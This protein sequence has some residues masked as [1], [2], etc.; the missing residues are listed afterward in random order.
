MKRDE[1]YIGNIS[2]A[3][4]HQYEPLYLPYYV[5]E[6]T[7]YRVDLFIERL[8]GRESFA[9]T[10]FKDPIKTELDRVSTVLRHIPPWFSTFSTQAIDKIRFIRRTWFFSREKSRS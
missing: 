10:Q 1:K 2:V 4:A 3:E 6:S 8:S 7:L 5:L 9:R